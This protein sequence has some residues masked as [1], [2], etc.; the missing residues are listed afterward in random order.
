MGQ[1]ASTTAATTT[2]TPTL[3][4]HDKAVMDMKVTRDKLHKYR[5]RNE[6]EAA[7]F[8]AKAKALLG[9]GKRDRA[10]LALRMKKLR[11]KEADRIEAQLTS[12]QELLM[13][14]ERAEMTLRVVEGLKSGNEALKR[15][16][17]LMPVEE[18]QRVLDEA[19]DER[20]KLDEVSSVLA[21]GLDASAEE[22]ALAELAELE[23]QVTSKLPDAPSHVVLPSAPVHSPT[24]SRTKED[25]AAAVTEEREA[26]A[27]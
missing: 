27:S 23:R 20:D 14:V 9:E 10:K 4:A 11:D 21:Q 16:N 1:A 15:L 7:L 19:Q 3:S 6:Q 24:R 18:V 2:T 12:L 17:A 13:G 5:K 8:V 25:T 22:E 26:V